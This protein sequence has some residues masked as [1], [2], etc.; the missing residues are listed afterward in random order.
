VYKY[1]GKWYA[2]EVTTRVIRYLHRGRYPL[3]RGGR[4]P[5]RSCCHAQFP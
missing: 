2:Q 5:L 3:R 4:E 1:N